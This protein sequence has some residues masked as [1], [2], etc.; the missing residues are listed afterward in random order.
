[1]ENEKALLTKLLHIE[2]VDCELPEPAS[3]EVLVKMEYCG[4]C[5]SDVHYY[6]DGRIGR[7]VVKFP[8]VLGHECA[9]EIVGVGAESDG[10]VIGDKVV[11]EPGL[12]C[13]RCEYCNT[14]RYN[15]CE[16]MIF[17]ATPPYHGA[18][19]R[20]V[21]YPERACH[22]LPKQVSTLEGAM[23]EPLAVGMHA[24]RR[25]G[26]DCSKTV[27]ITGAGC[28]G[29]MTLLSCKAMRAQKIIVSDIFQNRL[30]KAKELGADDVIRAGE[31]HVAERVKELTGGKGADIVFE[32]A[33]TSATMAQAVYLVR[34]GGVIMQV[35][36]TAEPV[37]YQ[38]NELVK[39]EADIRTVFRYRNIFPL[40]IQ[41]IAKGDI[42]LKAVGPN[43]FG[44]DCIA[45]AFDTAANR[46][47]DVIKCVVK[48]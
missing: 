19:Q 28:I 40:L 10:F 36:T 7:T 2:T 11:L 39:I 47:N 37:R 48:F 33:G 5:G 46:G 4:I 6:K 45:E 17:M 1:M 8:F 12:G 13:G 20:Y 41:L 23:I 22:K 34:R 25:S 31:E 16:K 38:F 32:T 15:L 29:L 44:F 24:A 3:G 42:N 14:G 43:I 35:G 30:D 9:G 27:L 18:F 26:V 21:A